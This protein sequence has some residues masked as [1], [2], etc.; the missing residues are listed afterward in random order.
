MRSRLLISVALLP[1]ISEASEM[2]LLGGT[3]AKSDELQSDLLS[4]QSLDDYV[5]SICQLA[6]PTSVLDGAQRL[7]YTRPWRPCK[8]RGKTF[9]DASLA[10]HSEKSCPTSSLQD[11]TARFSGQNLTLPLGNNT[12]PLDWLFG[13]SQTKRQSW[14]DA[15]RRTGSATDPSP[16]HKQT[17]TGKSRVARRVRACEAKVSGG[18]LGKLSTDKALEKRTQPSALNAALEYSSNSHQGRIPRSLNSNLPVI[19]EL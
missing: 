5:K 12:D 10:S 9:N 17:E 2:L 15:L 18:P 11:I 19:Y 13:E 7:P 8:L 3:Q 16:L 14:K 4:S 6:Q 1:T